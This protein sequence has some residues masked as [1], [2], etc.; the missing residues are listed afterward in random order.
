MVAVFDQVNQQIEHLRLDCD[1]FAAAGQLAKLDV[2]HMVGKVK[3]HASSRL[4]HHE[5]D[6]SRTCTD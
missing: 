6:L 5:I 4:D 3:L 2:E 1:A